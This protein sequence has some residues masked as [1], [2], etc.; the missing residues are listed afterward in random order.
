MQLNDIL[1]E[2]SVRAISQKTKISEDNLENLLAKK[3]ENLKK[4]KT[5][6]F[7][8][9]LER[10]YKADLN[11]LRND[12]EEY[13][14][15][16]NED[17][18]VMFG[19]SVSEEKKGT[20]KFFLFVVLLLLGYATWYFLTQ[21]DKKHL[22]ELIPFIDEATIESFMGDSKNP[23]NVAEDLSIAKISNSNSANE[24]NQAV[25]KVA[26]VETE[27]ITDDKSVVVAESV[28][29]ITPPVDIET[30]EMKKNII[31]IVPVGRLWF[32][33]IDMATN[34]RDHFSISELF[35]LD[36][37]SKSWL[38][39]TSSAPFSLHG[40]DENKEFNDAQEHYFKID[41]NGIVVLSKDEYVALG[42]W[43]Q[44]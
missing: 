16:L 13:Y 22:S 32:G 5:L 15:D 37:A 24:K 39:A 4:V 26:S 41:K 9:I 25:D 35:A 3:F 6:G 17:K 10:E 33:L 34:Q 21:F 11:A 8:S 36:V 19:M 12:A 30:S 1:E 27:V 40:T 28:T 20:S 2:N 31:S 29:D 42:G 43:S 44:W 18:S 23:M 7:I 38:V 14:S